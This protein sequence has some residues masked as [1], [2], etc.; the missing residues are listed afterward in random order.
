MSGGATTVLKR[1]SLT[2]LIGVLAISFVTRIVSAGLAV[3]PDDGPDEHAVTQGLLCPPS[4]EVRELL[5]RLAER[6]ADIDAR[7]AAVALREQDVAVALDEVV[8]MLDDL[9]TAEARLAARMQQSSEASAEDV[10]RLV[11]VYEGMKPKDAAILF[12]AMAP[13]FAAGFLARMRPASASAIFTSLAPDTAYALSVIMAG[14]N[15][16]AATEGRE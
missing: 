15:A 14:R 8:A 12:E 9:A 3:L 6:G 7:E 16:N 10:A 2:L 5:D 4:T 13:D 11:S 1:V